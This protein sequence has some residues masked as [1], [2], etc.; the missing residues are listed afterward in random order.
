MFNIIF[1]RTAASEAA[2]RWPILHGRT[3]N[4]TLR[5]DTEGT[6]KGDSVSSQSHTALERCTSGSKHDDQWD[7]SLIWGVTRQNALAYEKKE[8]ITRCIERTSCM[9]ALVR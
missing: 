2:P 9:I 3:T 1:R 7:G 6:S 4:N 5:E 8:P